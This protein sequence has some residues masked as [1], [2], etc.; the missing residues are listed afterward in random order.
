MRDTQKAMTE[1]ILK[2]QQFNAVASEAFENMENFFNNL[3]HQRDMISRLLAK[4]SASSGKDQTPSS[5]FLEWR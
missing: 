3:D 4:T 2:F 1:N 5:E